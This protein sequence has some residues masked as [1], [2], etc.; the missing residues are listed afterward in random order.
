MSNSAYSV[1]NISTDAVISC[2]LGGISLVG[3]IGAVI[4]SYMYSGNGPAVVG[5][6]GVG[7]LILA[8]VGIVFSWAAWKSQDG[9]FLMKRVAMFLNAIPLL[10]TV[11]LYIV[12]WIVS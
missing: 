3:M 7:S 5:L 6:M 10:G 9:G 12:G 4:A 8:V 1:K 2:A 11:I